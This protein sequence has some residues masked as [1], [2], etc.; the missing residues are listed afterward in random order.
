LIF[1]L[2][3]K[4]KKITATDLVKVTSLTTLSTLI[5]MATSFVSV[6]VVAVLIGPSG[7]ALLGQLYNFSTM[8]LSIS[9]GGTDK[10]MTKHIAQYSHSPRRYRLFLS[11]CFRLITTLGFL[12][13]LTIIICADYFSRSLLKDIQYKPVF[14]IFGVTIV[15]YALNQSLLAIINGFREFKKYV[16]VNI[17]GSIIGLIFS[18]ILSAKFGVFGALISLVT[19]Q[20]VTFIVTLSL[21]SKS[22]WFKKQNF[23]G[24]FSKTAAIRLSRYSLMA[25][26]S[27]IV[28][29]GA[30][31]IVRNFIIEHESIHQAGLW[32]GMNRISGNYLMLIISSLGVYYLPK[33]AG[34]KS[35]M[36]IRKEVITV[37][38]VVIPFLL[39][40]SLLIFVFRD[41]VIYILF[42]N[43]F[44]G[45]RDLFP[46]QLV[47]D[48]FK[49]GSWVLGYVLIARAMTKT[50]II[51][52]ILSCTFFVV[53]SAL[54]V[55][56]YGTIGATIGYA[57]GFFLHFLIMLFVFRKLLFK[58]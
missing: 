51:V 55:N 21:V 44:L 52:E 1:K 26:V 29:P 20:S 53:F 10:G 37:F 4:I 16:T 54:F 24:P 49:M 33:L 11:T 47:G 25:V 45:M 57:T 41:L 38:K 18:I 28:V 48:I 12:C 13:G 58:L 6:K 32:E 36:E 9:A 35:D 34:L 31:L 22:D 17:A 5:R 27:A 39:F 30:Q 15:L 3:S 2:L 43:K 46:F 56:M 19:Y 23:L 50:F 14:Y 7:V 40:A 8:C 42:D